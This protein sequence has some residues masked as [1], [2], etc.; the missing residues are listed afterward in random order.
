[1]S[2]LNEWC[3]QNRYRSFKFYFDRLPDGWLVRLYVRNEFHANTFVW[4]TFSRN[5]GIID[6][7]KK[8]AREQLALQALDQMMV[9]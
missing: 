1:M 2:R 4:G 3:Q 6:N 9:N 8:F 7:V 5:Q